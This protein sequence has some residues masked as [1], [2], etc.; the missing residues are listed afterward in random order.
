LPNCC[1]TKSV[2]RKAGRYSASHFFAP[3]SLSNALKQALRLYQT[4]Q[5]LTRQ[6]LMDLGLVFWRPFS[7][8]RNLNLFHSLPGSTRKLDA[9]GYPHGL[10]ACALEILH[11][12][13]GN[14]KTDASLVRLFSRLLLMQILPGLKST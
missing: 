8:R 13:A 14:H 10:S 9:T 1:V 2:N 12:V 5:H 7:A 11:T 3:S 4:Q 6:R